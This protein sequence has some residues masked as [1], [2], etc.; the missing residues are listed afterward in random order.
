MKTLPVVLLLALLSATCAMVPPSQAAWLASTSVTAPSFE[1]LTTGPDTCSASVIPQASNM[2]LLRD[3]TGPA[4]FRDSLVNV[5]PGTPTSSP[6][7]NNIPRGSYTVTVWW[8]DIAGNL[9]CSD[10]IVLAAR[11]QPAKGTAFSWLRLA[12]EQR[13]RL[14]AADWR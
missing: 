10:A 4:T 8:R 14:I 11:G 1:A 9:S 13:G 5:P 7:L 12:D 2:T 3:V 6:R